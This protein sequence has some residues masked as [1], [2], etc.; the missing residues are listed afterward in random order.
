VWA[1]IRPTCSSAPKEDDI[2]GL[3][4][5]DLVV[6]PI[7]R[8]LLGKSSLVDYG[9]IQSKFRCNWRGEYDG[10]GLVVLPKS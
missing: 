9:I 10:T 6:T 8:S 5:A 3:Q 2:A 7:G 4:V 1:G